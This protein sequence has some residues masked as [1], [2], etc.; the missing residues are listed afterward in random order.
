MNFRFHCSSTLVPLC[1]VRVFDR[2]LS[3]PVRSPCSPIVTPCYIVPVRS[4]PR[5]TPPLR[6]A[7]LFI[8]FS[9]F[10]V[11]SVELTPCTR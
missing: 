8:R 6:V 7:R 4:R 2:S 10:I 1:L 5:Y 11:Y 9:D 3:R